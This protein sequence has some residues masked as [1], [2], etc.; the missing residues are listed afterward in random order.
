VTAGI[1][2]GEITEMKVTGRFGGV[3]RARSAAGKPIGRRRG[4]KDDQ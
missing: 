1:V 3:L 2:A 4:A